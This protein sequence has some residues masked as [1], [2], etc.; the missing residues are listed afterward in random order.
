MKE[1]DLIGSNYEKVRSPIIGVDEVL[2]VIKKFD[3]KISIL[4]LGCGNGIPI[5][6]A[7]QK[8]A[9][10]YFGVDSSKVLVEEFTAN[11]PDAQIILASM[12]KINF[13]EQK[14]DLIIGF[15]SVFHL[16]PEKQKVALLKAAKLLNDKGVLMFTSSKE[17]GLCTGS[18]AGILVP[19]WSLGET[20]Y[21]ELLEKVGLLY[22]G[23][24]ICSGDNFI[25]YFQK[26]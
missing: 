15:G 23:G 22:E 1:Y 7:A 11:I 6:R 17:E 25:L 2:S 9:S 16:P 10:T 26:P 3:K 8:Y 20:N 24:K 4:D 18:V 12:D 19:H 14:F 13:K 5:A 21:I